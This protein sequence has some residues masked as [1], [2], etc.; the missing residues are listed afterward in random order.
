MAAAAEPRTL[1]R[2]CSTKFAKHL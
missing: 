1:E 2:L